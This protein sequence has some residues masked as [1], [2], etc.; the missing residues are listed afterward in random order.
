MSKVAEE[1]FFAL[2]MSRPVVTNAIKV[3]L[4]V[5]TILAF[6]NYGGKILTMSLTN[7]S[8]FQIFLTYLVPYCV[9]TYSAVRAL[10]ARASK[11]T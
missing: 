9:A 5:G 4:V 1:S 7:Q 2:V 11:S 8:I 6:I 3:A 10:E